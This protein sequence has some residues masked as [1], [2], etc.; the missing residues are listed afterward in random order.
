MLRNELEKLKRLAN[1]RQAQLLD[2]RQKVSVFYKKGKEHTKK[3]EEDYKKIHRD[4]LSAQI[5]VL[6]LE[7]TK[8]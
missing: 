5:K 8:L 4:N 2:I 3:L 7:L 6:D 1:E